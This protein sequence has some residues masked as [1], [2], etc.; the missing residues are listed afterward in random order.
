MKIDMLQALSSIGQNSVAIKGEI[1]EGNFL[2]VL[3]NEFVTGN[4]IESTNEVNVEDT[5]VNKGE[6]KEL[7]EIDEK[8]IELIGSLINKI[9]SIN[10]EDKVELKECD[11]VEIKV[12]LEN[13]DVE[14]LEKYFG[15]NVQ[16][17]GLDDNK[18]I[19][20][21]I[22]ENLFLNDEYYKN[23]DKSNIVN[24]TLDSNKGLNIIEDSIEIDFINNILKKGVDKVDKQV[25]N[26]ILKLDIENKFKEELNIDKI[27]I[28]ENLSVFGLNEDEISTIFERL[29]LKSDL[30]EV[31]PEINN[32]ILQY[33]NG[34]NVETLNVE[35]LINSTEIISKLDNLGINQEKIQNIINNI[36]EKVVNTNNSTIK[37]EEKVQVINIITEIVDNVKEVISKEKKVNSLISKT[38]NESEEK[39]I[40]NSLLDASNELHVMSSYRFMAIG[41]Q[42]I[43]L[44]EDKISN[45][46][47]LF[48]GEEVKVSLPK[49]LAY[50]EKS[51][52]D[53]II[54]DNEIVN[55]NNID[56][57]KVSN[58][59]DE[60]NI[61]NN[62]VMS[63]SCTVT[64]IKTEIVEQQV[65]SSEYIV[66]DFVE[67]INY[68]KVNNMEEI[69][70]KM[71]PKDLGEV[72]IKILKDN[73]Q[74]KII[75]TLNNEE[76]F[77]LL[78]ENVA[79]IKNHL[80][81]LDINVK[82]VTVEIKSGNENDFSQDL[83]QQFN[84]NNKGKNNPR[85]AMT[86]QNNKEDSLKDDNT[87]INLLI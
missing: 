70:V 65:I 79:D 66:E 4:S 85:H 16:N 15:S 24:E 44:A 8:L 75:V 47:S 13:I 71:N 25:D 35:E 64:E 56:K 28:K 11:D 5:L 62:I 42:P 63:K 2:S 49:I 43:K 9:N 52:K 29:N 84:K 81:N 21:I 37:I 6:Q 74:E 33:E 41:N 61:L 14:K 82:E 72:N 67:T 1:I 80:S 18:K 17:E 57:V 23:L 78:K 76:T 48:E 27:E 55:K 86:K 22:E 32:L 45:D 10:D 60:L 40:T 34:N 87:N 26:F 68:L 59:G 54:T 39:I 3:S 7:D 19:K 53:L 30:S 77:N 46:E 20:S 73:N 38:T 51:K 36:N 69:S 58:F 83:N 31:K 50:P 12:S